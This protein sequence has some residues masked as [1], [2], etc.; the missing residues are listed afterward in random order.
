ML[1]QLRVLNLVVDI[2]YSDKLPIF[3]IVGSSSPDAAQETE[4]PDTEVE[5]LI[6]NYQVPNPILANG[7]FVFTFTIITTRLSLE[8]KIGTA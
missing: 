2:K 6:L 7:H 4:D 3:K 5:E 8:N 1:S